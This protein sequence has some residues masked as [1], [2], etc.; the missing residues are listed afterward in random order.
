[1][2]EVAE[3][4]TDILAGATPTLAPVIE[5]VHNSLVHT[6]ED[7]APIVTDVVTPITSLVDQAAG[8]GSVLTPVANIL[9]GLLG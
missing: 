8:T 9:H 4:V 6:V 2:S 5:T 7:A 3:P 1:V